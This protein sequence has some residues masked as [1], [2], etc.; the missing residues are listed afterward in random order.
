M[1]VILLSISNS[2]M[3]VFNFSLKNHQYSR[4]CIQYKKDNTVD[5]SCL[6]DILFA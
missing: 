6:S 3:I 2:A 4:T 1:W 5:A